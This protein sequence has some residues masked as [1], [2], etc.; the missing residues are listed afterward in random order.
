MPFLSV[1]KEEMVSPVRRVMSQDANGIYAVRLGQGNEEKEQTKRSASISS[2]QVLV[3]G[4]IFASRPHSSF[5]RGCHH[6]RTPVF[7]RLFKYLFGHTDR[8]R[9]T[10]EAKSRSTGSIRW[11]EGVLIMK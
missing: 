8:H 7:H 11:L 2:V 9:I 4:G 1:V 10:F 5:I 6:N 3:V